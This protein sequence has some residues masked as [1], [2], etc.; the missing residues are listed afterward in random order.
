M[1][2]CSQVNIDS[3]VPPNPATILHNLF[4]S[5]F[6][7]ALG[8]KECVLVGHDWGGGVG[9]AVCARYP[10]LVRCYI[11]CNI[12]HPGAFLQSQRENWSQ[13]FKSWYMIFFQVRSRI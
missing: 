2:P 3:N 9:Y 12:A 10:E 13:R 7:S 4:F 8:R 6:L 1:I 5:P 11:A